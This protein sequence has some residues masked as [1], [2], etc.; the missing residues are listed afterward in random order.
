MNRREFLQLA[1]AIT[2]GA[3]LP[4]GVIAAATTDNLKHTCQQYF[5][6]ILEGFVRN[7]RATSPTFAVADF[8]DGTM[9]S[10]CCNPRLQTYVSTARMLPA[11]AA[12]ILGKNETV[13]VSGEKLDL[14]KLL[15]SAYSAAFNPAAPEYWGK[16]RTDKADQKQVEASLVAYS[17]WLVGEPLLS[18][19]TPADRTNINTWLASCT[20]VPERK[21]NH[22]WF[23]AINQAARLE[24]SARYTEFQGDEQWMLD[25]VKA[26]DGMAIARGW[27]NDWPEAEVYDYYN[28]W[29]YASHFLYW[30]QLC[31][32]KYAELQKRFLDRL[33]QFMQT[34]PN[35]FSA[36]GGH[37][38]FGRSLIYRWAMLTSLVLA[39]QQG[40]W[41]HGPGLLKRIIRMNFEWHWKLDPYDATHGKLRETYSPEGNH[42]VTERYIDN[43][44]PYWAMQAFAL[45][46]LP[47]DDPLWTAEEEPLPIQ[48]ADFDIQWPEL[49]MRLVG[50]KRTGHVQWLQSRNIHKDTY[51][52]KYIKFAYSSHF[53]FNVLAMKDRMPWDS[54]L[55][56]RDT[57]SGKVMGRTKIHSGELIDGGLQTKWSCKIGDEP[58][59]VTTRVLIDGECQVRRH[60]VKIP[61]ALRS[62][63]IEAIEG[64][65][66]LG[67]KRDEKYASEISQNFLVITAPSKFC[68]ACMSSDTTLVPFVAHTFEETERAD[69]NIIYPHNAVASVLSPLQN[70]SH[71]IVTA[72][73]ASPSPPPKHDLRQ[74]MLQLLSRAKA[75]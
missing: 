16:S 52:D 53:P 55:V 4:R 15:A 54:T 39:Y 42:E 40:L 1:A 67:L 71:T 33:A 44:H 41:P 21:H 51:R 49:G 29:T 36:E 70:E 63:V 66:P 20:V 24:L 58:I 48:K 37:V 75:L 61:E 43:G 60:D 26:L 27:Y 25:D 28:F 12:S 19:L 64:S 35:F 8:P 18:A 31:G 30:N 13:S 17:L 6:T 65:Y 14:V 56:F 38:L 62:A 7:A 46:A 50:T 73:Y 2:A 47:D 32:K 5:L 59:D 72:F 69:T 34:A 74:R 10:S 23:S 45:L 22:A 9:L 11:I 68:V 3:A 57:K